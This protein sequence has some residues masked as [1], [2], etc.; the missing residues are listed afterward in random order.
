M[1]IKLNKNTQK[2][3]SN[4]K[5]SGNKGGSIM[6]KSK[7]NPNSTLRKSTRKKKI[8]GDLWY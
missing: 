1:A 2:S 5:E 8:H 3:R 4:E 6:E 7:S